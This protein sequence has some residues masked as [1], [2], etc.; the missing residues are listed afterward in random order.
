MASGPEGIGDGARGPAPGL[1]VRRELV[2]AVARCCPRWLTEEADDLVQAAWLR[3]RARLASAEEE[4]PLA[5]SYLWRAAYCAVIDELR[6]RRRRPQ[7]PWD[8]A[9]AE[10]LTAPA[11][12][13]EDDARAAELGRAVREELA[14]ME[15]PRRLALTLH[16]E[17][18][19]VPEIAVLLGYGNKKA[20]NLVY[21]GLS[22]LRAG[23]EGRGWG[24]R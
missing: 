1:E 16:L 12:D 13:P 22:K 21:R 23:L 4:G 24:R 19:T 15:R 11:A 5:T 17:G 7:A 3:I 2:R 10:A 8:A 6:R 14:A 9:R 20:E 18:H